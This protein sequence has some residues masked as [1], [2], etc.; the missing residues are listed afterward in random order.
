MVDSQRLFSVNKHCTTQS[1]HTLLTD[2]TLDAAC[3]ELL[4]NTRPRPVV[5]R[6]PLVSALDQAA[7]GAHWYID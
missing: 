2:S 4:A 6:A 5:W 7:A 3:T 1:D